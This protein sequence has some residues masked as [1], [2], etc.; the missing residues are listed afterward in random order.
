VSSVM[1][2]H[3]TEFGRMLNQKTNPAVIGKNVWLG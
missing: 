2:H 3:G 1:R